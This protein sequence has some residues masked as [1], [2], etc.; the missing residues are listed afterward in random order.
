MIARMKSKN[1]G[2]PLTFHLAPLSCQNLRYNAIQL[3]CT[4]CLTR[5]LS[6]NVK[7]MKASG[8]LDFCLFKHRL[9]KQCM[10]SMMINYKR[11]AT[12]L[13]LLPFHEE[14]ASKQGQVRAALV[15]FGPTTNFTCP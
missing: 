2:Y 10:S 14:S 1:I 15:F 4:I 7:Q 6:H 11:R 12:A 13:Y 8:S 5:S 9:K 3:Y